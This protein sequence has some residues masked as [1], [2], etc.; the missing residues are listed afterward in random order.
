MHLARIEG[1]PMLVA[2]FVAGSL[3]QECL[4]HVRENRLFLLGGGSDLDVYLT[5]LIKISDRIG[6]KCIWGWS[7]NLVQL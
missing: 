1:L 6:G 3:G 5:H 4:L 7:R 2:A